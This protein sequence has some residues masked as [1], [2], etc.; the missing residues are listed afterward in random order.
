MT[1]LSDDDGSRATA[2]VVIP[3]HDSSATL[4]RALTSIDDPTAKILIVDDRSTDM[5]A[6]QTIVAA[7]PRATLIVKPARTNA[8]DSRA[9]GLTAAAGDLV[10][11]L[12]SDDHYLPGHIA[13]RRALH[14]AHSAGIII[15][16][17]RLSD[18]DQEWDGPM[19]AYEGG[20]VET[21][22]F[23]RGGDARSSTISVNKHALGSTSFDPRLAKHQDWGFVL[24]A[25]HNGERIGFDPSPGVVIDVAG[26]HRMSR[27]SNVDASLTFARDHLRLDQNRRLFLLQRLRT[28]LRIGDLRSARQFRQALLQRGPSLR[29]RCLSAAMILAAQLGLARPVHRLMTT[30]R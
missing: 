15:G 22:L 28:S 20:D 3:T 2:T 30:R 26:D 11:F 7:D 29:E 9:I 1:P 12:D 8:A 14:L 10:L 19:T 24:A 13:R 18:G 25:W 21:Y 27:G 17:F 16:R 5:T 6:L 23:A 4:A